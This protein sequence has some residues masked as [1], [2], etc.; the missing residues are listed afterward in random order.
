MTQYYTIQ[1]MPTTKGI[2]TLGICLALNGNDNDKFKYR[3]QQAMTSKQQLSKA[4]LG[5]EYTQI[6]FQSIWHAMI[7]YPLGATCF[8][9]QQCQKIQAE[10]LP[11]FLSW[12]GINRTTAM[13]VWHGPLHLGRFNVFNLEMEQGIMKTKMVISHL[14]WNNEVEKMLQISREHLQLQAG[15]PWLVMSHPRIQQCKYVDPCYL[16]H[17]WDFLDDIDTHLQFEL[18]QWLLP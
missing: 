9:T 14:W 16:S 15:V 13:V 7:Q 5:W 1:H 10:Y 17:L 18:N 6:G 2:C 11:M 3:I 8:T 4:P 12:M